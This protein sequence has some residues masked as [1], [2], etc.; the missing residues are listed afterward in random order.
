MQG[1]IGL[2]GSPLAKHVQHK[3]RQSPIAFQSV[4]SLESAF[5]PEVHHIGANPLGHIGW[6][7]REG[8]KPSGLPNGR[9]TEWPKKNYVHDS[10]PSLAS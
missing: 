10:S 3:G 5:S 7:W 6:M 8:A 9:L 2:K 4:P 1:Q